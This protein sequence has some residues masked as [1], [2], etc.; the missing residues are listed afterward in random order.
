MADWFNKV[1]TML[2]VKK[3]PVKRKYVRKSPAK[4][5]TSSKKAAPSTGETNATADQ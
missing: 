2:G 5:R 3:A 1:L 4:P